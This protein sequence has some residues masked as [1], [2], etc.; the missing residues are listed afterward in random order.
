[1][2]EEV[3]SDE[4]LADVALCL[5]EIDR[6]TGWTRTE[7]VGKLILGRF[8]D[9]DPSTWKERKGTGDQSLRRLASRPECP[10]KKSA[11]AEAVGVYVIMLEEPAVRG[12]RN[13]SP[14]HVARV[15]NLETAARRK[16]LKEAEA[17][18]QSVRA[19][20]DQVRTLRERC[21]S[22]RRRPMVEKQLV[23]HLIT[24]LEHVREANTKA[25]FPLPLDM[26]QHASV[27]EAVRNITEELEALRQLV[28]RRQKLI[29]GPGPRRGTGLVVGQ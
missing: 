10:L 28:G 8:F 21:G 13:L 7:A 16:L 20:A 18:G 12:A 22:A 23:R 29:S 15:L 24:A 6:Q 2:A 1:V 5:R 3:I 19:L 9:G 26:E 4:E 17:T 25:D 11:L 27:L 14:S